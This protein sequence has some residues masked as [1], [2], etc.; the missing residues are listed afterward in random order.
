MRFLADESCDI[1]VAQALRRAGHDVVVIFETARGTPDP[2]VL[3]IALKDSR[4]LLTEDRDF[5]QLVFAGG[6]RSVPAVLYFR[7]R[8]SDRASL[9]AAIVGLVSRLGPKLERSFVVWTPRRVRV[10][11]LEAD[12][13]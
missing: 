2:E 1:R 4:I 12:Q 3:E 8:Q 5:G 7:C 11:R 13:S 6:Y 10:R 9:P